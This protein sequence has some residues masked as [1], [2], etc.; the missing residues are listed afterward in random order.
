MLSTES[1]DAQLFTY[2]KQLLEDKLAEVFKSQKL[3]EVEL[4]GMKRAM[5]AFLNHTIDIPLESPNR[6]RRNIIG[7]VVGSVIGSELSRVFVRPL[8]QPFVDKFLC[9]VEK[10]VPF[11]SI[12]QNDRRKAIEK[13]SQEVQFL[14]NQVFLLKTS[15]LEA[16][17]VKMPAVV[18]NR[19]LASLGKR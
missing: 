14:E 15:L 9:F 1:S 16:I 8:R 4:Q 3:F 19:K 17:M 5:M 10:L 11:G 2:W 12:C 18:E 13:L 7:A 6:Y